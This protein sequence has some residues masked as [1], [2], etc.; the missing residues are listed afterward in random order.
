MSRSLHS[1][2]R[3]PNTWPCSMSNARKN[4]KEKWSPSKIFLRELKPIIRT[5][6]KPLYGRMA[7]VRI[8]F[9]EDKY[10]CATKDYT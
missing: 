7:H 3:K 8:K 9:L 6:I 1:D 4:G 2:Q 10:L 5:I